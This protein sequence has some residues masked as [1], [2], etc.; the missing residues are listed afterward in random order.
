MTQ[1]IHQPLKPAKVPR[2]LHA[3]T[4]LPSRKRPVKL[5]RL[6]G[7]AQS[8]LTILARLLVDKGNLLKPRMKIASY[9]HHARLLSSQAVGRYAA[10]SLLRSR[11]PTL[12]CNQ[13]STFD[14]PVFGWKVNRPEYRF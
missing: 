6:P 5:L 11:E 8:A 12:S 7:V 10:T 1:L 14:L 9:N 13:L 4:N 2:C 3:D